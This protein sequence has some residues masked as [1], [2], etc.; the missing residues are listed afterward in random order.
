MYPA[1][2]TKANQ[3]TQKWEKGYVNHPND[4]GGATYNGISLRFLK[5]SGIDINGDGKI[6]IQDILT[7]YRNGDQDKVDE[8]YY[9]AFW[10]D[11]GFDRFKYPALQTV[12]FDTAVNTGR[13][14]TAKMLQ[15]A[16]NSITPAGL[17][18]LQVDGMIGPLTVARALELSNRDNGQKLAQAFL[19]QRMSFHNQLVDNSPY[20]DGR[21]YKPFAAGWRN[22]VND[23]VKYVRGIRDVED[24]VKNMEFV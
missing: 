3:F 24:P 17:P 13:T 5:Q 18:K 6:D 12:L 14:Q 10:R 22:R 16:C 21:N 4:P 8:I 23:L 9:K 15:R 7:L 19:D 2:F 1:N 11:P 20:P